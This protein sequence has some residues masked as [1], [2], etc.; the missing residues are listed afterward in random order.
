MI[1]TKVGRAERENRWYLP[2]NAEEVLNIPLLNSG[3]TF[4]LRIENEAGN[5][6]RLLGGIEIHF[7]E[8]TD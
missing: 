1:T 6:F 4:R 2:Q 8:R 3:R 5:W 7:D